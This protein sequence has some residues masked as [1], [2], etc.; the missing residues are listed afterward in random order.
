MNKSQSQNHVT[1]SAAPTTTVRPR[2]DVLETAESLILVADVPGVDAASI[3][4]E[5][6]EDVLTL[7]ARSALRAPEGWT[8]AGAEFELPGY[9]RSFRLHADIDREAPV[10]S[11]QNG[12]LKVVLKKRLPR[13]SRIEVKGASAG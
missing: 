3:E 5:L 8:P 7:R 12:R 10:A 4:L 1:Q 13:A 11:V 2:T 6:V 9:E